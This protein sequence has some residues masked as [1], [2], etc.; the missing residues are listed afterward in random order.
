MTNTEEH[1]LNACGNCR[2]WIANRDGSALE[3]AELDAMLAGM[4]RNWPAAEW[5]LISDG[6]ELGC[7]SR[8]CDVCGDESHGDRY[9]VWAVRRD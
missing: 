1:E 5:H 3:D 2:I 4:E 7:Y 9:R 8:D 6:T